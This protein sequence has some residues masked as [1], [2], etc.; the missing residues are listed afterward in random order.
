ML[1][2]RKKAMSAIDKQLFLIHFVGHT[3]AKIIRPHRFLFCKNNNFVWPMS[4][5]KWNGT[6]VP[7][8]KTLLRKLRAMPVFCI[9]ERTDVTAIVAEERKWTV[10]DRYKFDWAMDVD[11]CVRMKSNKYDFV[12]HLYKSGFSVH[13]QVQPKYT[14]RYITNH[15]FCI[16]RANNDTLKML[17]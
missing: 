13:V 15:S 3:I 1:R 9:L 11:P 8:A 4:W 2:I 7:T 10:C 5:L 17:I 16:C 6:Q 12:T 14:K